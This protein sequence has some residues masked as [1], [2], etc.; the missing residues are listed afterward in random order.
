LQIAVNVHGGALPGVARLAER[1]GGWAAG[2]VLMFDHV[3]ASEAATERPESR[4][5]LFDY[6]AAELFDRLPPE[7]RHLLLRTALVP[8]VSVEM[9]QALTGNSNAGSL[10]E[11][12]HRKH[13]FTD[14]RAGPVASYQYHALFREFLTA[15]V[16]C[17]G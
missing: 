11:G 8:W 15:R 4:Q 9:A 3:K 17:I 14:R 2:L 6:F 7:T 10:L 5:A 16:P 13:L 1:C 12:L